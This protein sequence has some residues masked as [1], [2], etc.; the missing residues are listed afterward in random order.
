[1][2]ALLLIVYVGYK[3]GGL[4]TEILP[5]DQCKSVAQQIEKTAIEKRWTYLEAHCYP[6]SEANHE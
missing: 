1:M 4:S 2:K 6:L 3:A 5:L